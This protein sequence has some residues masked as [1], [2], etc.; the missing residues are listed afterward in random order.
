MKRTIKIITEMIHPLILSL[1]RSV[2]NC[3]DHYDEA[4]EM[5]SYPAV[6]AIS[7]RIL[8]FLLFPAVCLSSGAQLSLIWPA[9]NLFICFSYCQHPLAALEELK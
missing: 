2:V 6:S 4:R 5:L 3:C 9:G 7:C 8:L 1:L